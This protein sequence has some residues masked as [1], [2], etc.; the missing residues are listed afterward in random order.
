M[1]MEAS[2]DFLQGATP[3]PAPPEKPEFIMGIAALLCAATQFC[4]AAMDTSSSKKEIHFRKAGENRI[5]TSGLQEL[6]S[7]QSF[8]TAKGA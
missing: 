7:F 4:T 1:P 5:I 6:Q 2:S 8:W 3:V